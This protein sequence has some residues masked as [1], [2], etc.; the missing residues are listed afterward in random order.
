MKRTGVSPAAACGVVP[1]A[2]AGLSGGGAVIAETAA[3]GPQASSA[4]VQPP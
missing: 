4:A 1:A 2:V 3:P